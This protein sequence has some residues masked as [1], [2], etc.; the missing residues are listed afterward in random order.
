MTLGYNP[1]KIQ[2]AEEQEEQEEQREKTMKG[3]SKK[4]AF[5]AL[6]L[7]V[8]LAVF[9][10]TYEVV[11]TNKTIRQRHD[12][13]LIASAIYRDDL[14]YLRRVLKSGEDPNQMTQVGRPLHI[15]ISNADITDNTIG[16][17]KLLV[18]YGADVRLAD[19][20]GLTPLHYVVTDGGSESEGLA[21][22]LLE[23]GADPYIDSGTGFDSPYVT[24]LKEGNG[25]VAGAIRSRIGHVE[26][27]NLKDLQ[28]DG[29]ISKMIDKLVHT[30][31]L[32]D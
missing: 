20:I 13:P 15:A 19:K 17:V 30:R 5:F 28:E 3:F 12:M 2:V 7:A 31:D 10:V 24:A 11:G 16:I 32:E 27:E 25:G 18:E 6:C 14:D 9:F 22:T 8:G 1:L 26:P 4:I 21:L 23:A 29:V